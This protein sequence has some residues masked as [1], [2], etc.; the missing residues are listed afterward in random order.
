VGNIPTWRRLGSPM[1]GWWVGPGNGVGSFAGSSGVVGP[2]VV[3]EFDRIQ[4][5]GWRRGVDKKNQRIR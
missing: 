1:G 2:M 4:L 3:D 5:S